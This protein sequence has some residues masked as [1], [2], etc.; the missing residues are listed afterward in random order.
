M[1]TSN[2]LETQIQNL[3]EELHL[4]GKDSLVLKPDSNDE[5]KI[6]LGDQECF[7]GRLDINLRVLYLTDFYTWRETV[8]PRMLGLVCKNAFGFSE[9]HLVDKVDGIVH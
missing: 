9:L 8:E 7:L 6:I 5:I 1:S 3:N 4:S 2:I